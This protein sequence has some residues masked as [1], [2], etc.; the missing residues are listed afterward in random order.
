MKVS[1]EVQNLIKEIKEVAC[2]MVAGSASFLCG[3]ALLC[4][5]LG[6]LWIQELLWLSVMPIVLLWEQSAK[7]EK[8][9]RGKAR[10]LE[11]EQE[12]EYEV[13]RGSLDEA[14]KQARERYA[15]LNAVLGKWASQKPTIFER[16]FFERSQ[17]REE[18]NE[19]LY[20]RL[21]EARY[22]EHRLTSAQ[23]VAKSDKQ[24]FS[25]A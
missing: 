20:R 18:Q 4:I 2:P 17:R 6:G 19:C 7:V 12:I 23:E 8:W 1:L 24:R 9:A 14:I 16:V 22:L 3:V 25:D 5:V 21:M 11:L 15:V 10:W 13:S